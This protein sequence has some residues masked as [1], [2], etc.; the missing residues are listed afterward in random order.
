[1]HITEKALNE[2]RELWIEDHPDE[3]IDEKKLTDIAR[4]VLCAMELIYKAM[5][6]KNNKDNEVLQNEKRE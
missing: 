5:P 2:F 4:R 6:K 3:D 1:M